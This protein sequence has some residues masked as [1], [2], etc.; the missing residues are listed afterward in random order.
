MK[1]IEIKKEKRIVSSFIIFLLTILIL[2]I[3]SLFIL[4]NISK[5]GILK[6]EILSKK[7]NMGFDVKIIMK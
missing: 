6:K 4:L 7:S 1:D 2:F 5:K 3:D